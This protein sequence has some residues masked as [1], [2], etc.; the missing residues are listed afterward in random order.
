MA[1]KTKVLWVK[2][3]KGI[4]YNGVEGDHQV[5]LYEQDDRH[6]VNKEAFIAGPI[7]VQV[8]D[9]SA[10]SKLLKDGDI[11]EVSEAEARRSG[12]APDSTARVEIEA[13]QAALLARSEALDKREKELG[14]EA[15][16]LEDLGKA[17]RR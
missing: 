9:T 2:A 7:P 8:A 14:A 13:Q 11:E 3:I 5:L 12:A 16:R 1:D 4:D 17:S 6:P 10:V 15:K